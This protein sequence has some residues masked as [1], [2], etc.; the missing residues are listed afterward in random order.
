M[1]ISF[2]LNETHD[3]G[4]TENRAILRHVPVQNYSSTQSMPVQWHHCHYCRPLVGMSDLRLSRILNCHHTHTH[5]IPPINYPSRVSHSMSVNTLSLESWR[6]VA[7]M[8][9]LH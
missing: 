6:L 9:L 8:E 1:S 4:V 7:R 5:I 3:D 2:S